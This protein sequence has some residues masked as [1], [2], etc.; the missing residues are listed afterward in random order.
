M[1]Y[2]DPLVAKSLLSYARLIQKAWRDNYLKKTERVEVTA[3]NINDLLFTICSFSERSERFEREQER[4]KESGSAVPS[5][6]STKVKV[7]ILLNFRTE[8]HEGTKS[9]I[10]FLKLF[11]VK[12]G[13][14][15]R[16][17]WVKL[18]KSQIISNES[19]GFVQIASLACQETH[20]QSLQNELK[21]RQLKMISKAESLLERALNLREAEP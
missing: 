19:L 2:R 3:D 10:A 13:Q 14:K 9:I 18:R 20:T 11:P 15:E 17:E 21:V 12:V 6:R 5:F 4:E 8:M 16:V 1:C 7:G